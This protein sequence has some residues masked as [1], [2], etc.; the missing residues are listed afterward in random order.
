VHFDILLH[1]TEWEIRNQ[2]NKSAIDYSRVYGKNISMSRQ[3][4]C[5]RSP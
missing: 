5:C 4:G 3:Q 1:F 2:M